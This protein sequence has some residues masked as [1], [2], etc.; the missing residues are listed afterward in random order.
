MCGCKKNRSFGGGR[1][2]VVTPRQVRNG[3]SAQ[4]GLRAITSQ[5]NRAAVQAQGVKS[6]PKQNEV[7]AQSVTNDNSTRR[8]L[9]RDRREIERKRRLAIAKKNGKK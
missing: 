2:R 5:N 3:V 4:Q 8:K 6:S 9:T 7:T 1:R